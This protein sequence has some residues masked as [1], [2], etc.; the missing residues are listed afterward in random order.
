VVNLRAS[1]ANAPPAVRLLENLP[2]AAQHLFAVVETLPVVPSKGLL[3]EVD[4]GLTQVRIEEF[5][6]ERDFPIKQRRVALSVAEAR[7][8]PGGHFIKGDRQRIALGVHVPT[9][10]FPQPE[11]WLQVRRRACSNV[12]HWSA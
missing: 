8:L 3:E 7:Q 12:I 9:R 6:I 10:G 2:P 1:V 11:K 5:R 4:H